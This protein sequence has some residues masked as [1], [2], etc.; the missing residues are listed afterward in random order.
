MH[1]RWQPDDISFF[2]KPGDL[3]FSIV[4]GMLLYQFNGMLPGNITIK[5]TE[6]FP[7]TDRLQ[8]IEVPV[9]Q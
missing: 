7:V 8:C 5:I 4:P 1:L 9:R 2:F 3:S 6:Q